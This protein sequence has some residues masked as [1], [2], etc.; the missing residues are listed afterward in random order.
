M[1][2][3]RKCK[4]IGAI[5]IGTILLSLI[6]SSAPGGLSEWVSRRVVSEDGQYVLV[7]ISSHTLDEEMNF[8]FLKSYPYTTKEEK[9]VNEQRKV[10]I[11]AIRDKYASGGM[12][13]NDDSTTPLWTCGT[14]WP[15]YN[16]I[17]APDG[18]H[19]VFPGEWITDDDGDGVCVATFTYRG[20]TVR[21][22]LIDF[23]PQLILKGILNGMEVPNCVATSFDPNAMT[24]SLKTNQHE[25][26]VF[27]VKTGNII[28]THSPFPA[29]FSLAAAVLVGITGWIGWQLYRR[30][31][32]H[33]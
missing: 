15:S 20:Q 21:R 16:P 27:D 23:I 32:R 6:A 14:P 12:Y 25:E 30:R 11:R 3:L 7:T 9:A 29:L 24:Y 10:E 13:L 22:C 28:A 19:I 18:D 5:P 4:A 33:R 1:P 17:I 31:Y 2:A 8:E 26:F